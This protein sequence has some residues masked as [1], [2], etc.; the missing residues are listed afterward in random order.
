MWLICSCFCICCCNAFGITIPLPFMTTP[1]ITAM[2]SE[3]AHYA[4][5]SCASW[6]LLLGHPCMAYSIRCWR[7]WS[8]DVASCTPCIVIHFGMLVI[9]CIA[10]ILVYMPVISSSLFLPWLCL[11]SQSAM[12][13]SGPG[14]Y[15]ILTLYWCILC[16][17]VPTSFLKMA[18]SGLWSMIILIYL[19]KQ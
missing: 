12:N 2:S 5:M 9:D 13:R 11:D 6:F 4:L 3:N 14:L 7:C 1:L 8:W 15:I 16:D 18:T 17:N 19:T 10:L